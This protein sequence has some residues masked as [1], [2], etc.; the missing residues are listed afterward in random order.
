MDAPRFSGRKPETPI[1]LAHIL[2]LVANYLVIVMF[3]EVPASKRSLYSRSKIFSVGINDAPYKVILR[4]NGK[5]FRCPAY[6]VWSNM[7]KRCYSTLCQEKNKTY[8]DCTV[9]DEWLLFS[10][11][12]KWI[13][14]K[15]IEGNQLDKDLIEPGNRVYCPE[16]CLMISG[17]LNKFLIKHHSKES[18]LPTGVIFQKDAG[19]FRARFCHSGKT[20]HLGYFKTQEEARSVY[21]KRK[22]EEFRKKAAL[23]P[24]VS[25]YLISFAVELEKESELLNI[26]V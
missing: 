23:N 9:C 4:K 5:K 14:G 22:A 10:N 26:G 2:S 24:S 15:E 11:F 25:K 19:M 6:V 18:N 8:S 12:K 7:I 21:A 16:K 20:E 3:K 17:S 1:R 13:D